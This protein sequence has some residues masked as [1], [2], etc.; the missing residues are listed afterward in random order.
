MN[1][2]PNRFLARQRRGV[3]TTLIAMA[4]VVLAFTIAGL[5][6]LPY[7][8]TP[9]LTPRSARVEYRVAGSG[10]HD[11][12]FLNDLG[13]DVTQTVDAPWI[14]GFRARPG[15]TLSLEVRGATEAAVECIITINGTVVSAQRGAAGVSCQATIPS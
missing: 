14:Y 13:F 4:V 7:S 2:P 9:A 5:A 11:V 3:R 6:L 1:Q 10:I 12:R 15:R 8:T